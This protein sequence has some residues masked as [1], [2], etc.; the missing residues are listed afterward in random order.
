VRTLHAGGDGEGGLAL[1]RNSCLVNGSQRPHPFEKICREFTLLATPEMGTHITCFD[2][3][4]LALGL[5]R[6]EIS[7]NMAV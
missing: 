6:L 2:C 4:L 1:V 7:R 3:T 5:P